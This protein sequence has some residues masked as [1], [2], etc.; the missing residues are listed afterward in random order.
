MYLI[1]KFKSEH[2]LKV[3]DV[4]AHSIHTMLKINSSFMCMP[5]GK[6]GSKKTFTLFW[7]R[8]DFLFQSLPVEKKNKTQYCFL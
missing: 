3:F 6:D 1:Q 8:E 5:K 7:A 4:E 2:V